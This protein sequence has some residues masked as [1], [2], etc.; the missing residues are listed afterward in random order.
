M[1]AKWKSLKKFLFCPYCD[2]EMM[3]RALPYCE[4]CKITTFYCP[5]C[6]KPL[7]RDNKICPHC[8]V[9]IKG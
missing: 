6:R 3:K 9:E 4:L 8:G 7:S 5:Q 1:G 2:E